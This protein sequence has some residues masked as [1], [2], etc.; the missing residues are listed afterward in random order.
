MSDAAAV[1]SVVLW[2][3]VA[4]RKEPPA[5]RNLLTLCW[6]PSCPDL[7]PTTWF[8][9][10]TRLATGDFRWEP[11]MEF[12]PIPEAGFT[13]GQVRSSGKRYERTL[14]SIKVSAAS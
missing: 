11:E 9:I 12:S 7:P 4:P 1:S 13:K 5:G 6:R 2:D 3:D 10:W 14:E 8:Y